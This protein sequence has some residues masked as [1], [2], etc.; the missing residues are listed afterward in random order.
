MAQQ[1]VAAQQ[2]QWIN[3][4]WKP[5]A[6][7]MPFSGTAFN[8]MPNDVEAER[9]VVGWLLSL[10][11]TQSLVGYH[12]I[13]TLQVKDFWVWEYAMIFRA[14]QKQAEERQAFDFTSIVYQLQ[15]ASTNGQSLLEQVGGRE[16]LAKLLNPEPISN[17]AQLA[18]IIRNHANSRSLIYNA[19][20]Q[21]A[22]AYD[23]SKDAETRALE[24]QK[25][26]QP[27]LMHASSD[28]VIHSS[29]DAGQSVIDNLS[30]DPSE[31]GIYTGYMKLTE[32]LPAGWKKGRMY[33]VGGRTGG[34]KSAFLLNVALETFTQNKRVLYVSLEMDEAA[35]AQRM[36]AN[37]ASI[38]NFRLEGNAVS[39]KE[40]ADLRRELA[41]WDELRARGAALDFCIL[42]S[43]TIQQLNARIL[44][45]E[46]QAGKPY[47][48]IIVD[49]VG[50]EVMSTERQTKD[51]FA[52][53]AELWTGMRD[54]KH[55]FSAAW[56]V[57]AQLNRG[58]M[59]AEEPDLTHIHGSSVAEKGAD[60]VILLQPPPREATGGEAR[61]FEFIIAKSREGQRGKF[62]M[63][64]EGEYMRFSDWDSKEALMETKHD[65]IGQGYV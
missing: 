42:N 65:Q 10:S 11:G 31:L 41:A 2:L 14:A 34:G 4:R 29:V 30:K 23:K 60:L 44:A 22:L 49:Y 7:L 17:P 19:V 59:N 53:A 55:H 39:E 38:N 37:C 40:K 3:Q 28:T 62:P 54:I 24:A 47:D 64:F 61:R 15:N 45:S 1:N 57:G 50:A 52:K 6:K 32:F 8:T 56:V 21:I 33:I 43:P 36:L 16:A 12:S 9:Q 27:I 46:M 51:D 48:M 18:Q 58:A 20:Q 25:A 13:R 26:L 5:D 63:R 35:L